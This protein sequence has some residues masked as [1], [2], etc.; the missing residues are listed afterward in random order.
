MH[1]VHWCR[2][3]G[4]NH[5]LTLGRL[6]P[7]EQAALPRSLAGKQRLRARLCRGAAGEG[8]AGGGDLRW[9]WHNPEGLLSVSR[10]SEPCATEH[11][12][13]G[14]TEGILVDVP[15]YPSESGRKAEL[16]EMFLVAREDQ[17]LPPVAPSS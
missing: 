13:E 5:S 11:K 7:S 17:R 6:S 1:Y 2:N 15:V 3:K 9:A 16:A 12:P 10:H 8:K 14:F 4:S